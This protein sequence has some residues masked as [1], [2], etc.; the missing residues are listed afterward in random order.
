MPGTDPIDAA[1]TV[2]GELPD[3]PHL[4]ELPAR[5]VGA[6]LIGRTG[7]ILVDLPFEVVPSGYRVAGR[8]GRDQRRAVDLLRHDLDA[9]QD[10]VERTGGRPQAIKVQAA[11]PWTL[12]TSVELTRGHKVLTDTGAL[13]EFTA[14]LIE[15]L[16]THVAEV[17]ARTGLD[18]L[19]QLDEPS[20]PAVLRGQVATPSGYGTVAAVPEPEA[21]DVLAAVIG[22]V[23]QAT[24]NPVIVHCCAH[25]P[26]VSLLHQAGAG[27]LALDFT[28]EFN[29][30]TLDELG[31]A[32]DAGTVLLLGLVPSVEP[33]TWPTLAQAAAPALRL[34]DQLG[35]DRELLARRA[36][37]TPTC[38][39]AGASTAW[40]RRALSLVRDLG[41]AFVEPP[42]GW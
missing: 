39:L 10:A 5:G 41:Q 25:Q 14:S 3:L 16:A 42:E 21:R 18:V 2:F 34:V 20:L 38:G 31:Q 36:V 37:P 29:P 27:A 30:S 40:L 22:G 12:A 6:D 28:L 4:P 35:F 23:Q 8:P 11:G 1:R 24:G 13:R 15:G 33:E 26:P 32:W 17:K 7:A 9:V 19:L